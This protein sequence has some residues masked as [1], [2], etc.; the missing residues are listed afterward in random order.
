MKFKIVI[1][2]I[3]LFFLGALFVYAFSP[4]NNY[5]LAFFLLPVLL[6]SYEKQDGRSLFLM[7]WAMFS[8]FFTAIVYWLYFSLHVYAHAGLFPVLLAI[9]GFS[10]YL[11]LFPALSVSLAQ[12]SASLNSKLGLFVAL[13]AYF[14]IF[15]W[16]RG[17]LFTGFP[18]AALGYSQTESIF[19]QTAS[20][21]G[22]YG[23]S[24]LTLIAGST[25]YLLF[26]N[27]VKQFW[28][29]F[30]TIFCLGLFS[31]WYLTMALCFGVVASFLWK[32]QYLVLAIPGLMVFALLASFIPWTKPI[33]ESKLK[34]ALLQGSINQAEKWLKPKK[35]INRYMDLTSQVFIGTLGEKN[36]K[37]DVIIWPETAI[38]KYYSE[39]K[40]TV[41]KQLQS[42]AIASKTDF[43]VG[44][45]VDGSNLPK[46]TADRAY[47]SVIKIGSELQF[48]SKIR[49]VPYGEYSPFRE[50]LAG[51]YKLFSI[52]MSNFK[53]GEPDQALLTVKNHPIGVFMIY[54][55]SKESLASSS[56]FT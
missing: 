23:L 6:F 41:F 14:V 49:L 29:L 42:L 26:K 7:S 4:F 34:L 50:S 45:T 8:G 53:K 47:N 11:A 10:C 44:I 22:V 56:I 2:Y 21:F 33:K 19:G 43:I 48:Y 24:A 46:G 5:F 17:W 15:E 36:N 40:K 9:L 52:D 31:W 27:H 18:W 13:P 12:R 37:P 25:I 51:F 3:K 28:I 35:S 38:P 39:V 54:R 30:A 55:R 32:R 20:L 1:P 16:L